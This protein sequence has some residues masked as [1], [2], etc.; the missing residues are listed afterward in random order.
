MPVHEVHALADGFGALHAR[1]APPKCPQVDFQNICLTVLQCCIAEQGVNTQRQSK[2][3]RKTRK[4]KRSAGSVRC[5]ITG[6]M[7]IS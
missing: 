1:Q 5:S 2:R 6:F 7:D 3:M 4:G